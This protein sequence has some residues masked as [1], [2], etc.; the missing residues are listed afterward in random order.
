MKVYVEIAI[1]SFLISSNVIAQDGH[2]LTGE[3]SHFSRVSL[4]LFVSM[5]ME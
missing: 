3:G 2:E 5:S 1:I 4:K